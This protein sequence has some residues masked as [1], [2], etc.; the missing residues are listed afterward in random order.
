VL[1]YSNRKFK[2]AAK[3]Q[4]IGGWMETLQPGFHLATII[5][6]LVQKLFFK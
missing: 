1:T 2:N 4:A 5:A 3:Q 6:D